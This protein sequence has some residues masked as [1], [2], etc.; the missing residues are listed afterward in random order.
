[1]PLWADQRRSGPADSLTPAST[2]HARPHAKRAEVCC[3][4]RR[5]RLHDL[6]SLDGLPG[7]KIT[8]A[9]IDGAAIAWLGA[10]ILSVVRSHQA[11]GAPT[12]GGPDRSL[13]GEATPSGSRVVPLVSCATRTVTRAAAGSSHRQ[14]RVRFENSAGIDPPM[15]VAEV[16]SSL[17]VGHSVL[18]HLDEPAQDASRGESASA[19]PGVRLRSVHG[20]SAACLHVG[21]TCFQARSPR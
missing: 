16:A 20:P 13:L 12:A 15:S 19:R 7:A 1:M 18:T 6:P 8:A 3:V 9:D 14:G 10:H 2:S 21:H 17:V 5:F 11:G 4:G